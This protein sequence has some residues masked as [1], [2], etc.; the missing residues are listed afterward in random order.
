M[1]GLALFFLLAGCSGVTQDL[2]DL[3]D[4][5]SEIEMLPQDLANEGVDQ[6][7]RHRYESAVETFRQLKDRYPYS[8]Y[9]ILAELKIA[10][11]LFLQDK[12][13]EALTAYEEFER[14]HPKN[15]AVPYVIYQQGMCHFKQIN[16]YDR[17][18]SS[19]VRAIQTFVRL[20]QTYPDSRYAAMGSAKI[21]EAQEIL[22]HHEYAVGLYYF[23]NED[24]KAAEGRFISLIENYPDSGYHLPA[25]EYIRVCREKMSQGIE[26]GRQ[27]P[28]YAVE[29]A[30]EKKPLPPT[31]TGPPVDVPTTDP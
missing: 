31:N 6:L 26:E 28:E 24:Y 7:S 22:A 8:K 25:L 16:G 21:T 11:A 2:S 9:A 1:I 20:I 18:Q 19:T 23:K 13:N 30:D 14:L 17:E 5:G 10:D 29:A 4:T 12:Y 3:F 27:I 15:E